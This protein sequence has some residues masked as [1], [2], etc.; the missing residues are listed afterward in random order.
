M[1]GDR[2]AAVVTKRV[3]VIP[4]DDAAPEAVLPSLQ[5]LKSM[6]LD[7]DYLELPTG[8]EGRALHGDRFADVCRERSTPPIPRSSGRAAGRLRR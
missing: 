1:G 6:E 4:G 3:C 8:A 7:L 2:T 5:L